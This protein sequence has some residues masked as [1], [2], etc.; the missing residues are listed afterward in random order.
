[1]A[2]PAPAAQ[3]LGGRGASQYI[4]DMR[5]GIDL[6]GTKIE[7]IALGDDGRER[8]RHRVA[9]PQTYE[10][11][12]GALATLVARLEGEAAARGTVGVGTPGFLQPGRGLIRNSN[13][14]CLNDR[15]LDV[16]L[17]HALGRQVRLDND[18]SCFVLSEA[19]DGAA[20]GPSGAPGTKADVVFGATLGTGVGGGL[21]IDGR[22]H[23]GANGAAAEWS[24]TTLPFLRAGE[25]S[26]YVCFCGHAGCIES[27]TSGRGL[28]GAYREVGG[29]P[30]LAAPEVGARAA[31]GEDVAD[32][33]FD[34]YEDRL[35]RA[36][37]GVINLLDPRAIVL[38]G[39]VSNNTRLFANLPRL[40]ERYTV[41]K[42]LR[43]Q[44][45]R[46]LHGDA[47][48]VRGAAFL[49]PARDTQKGLPSRGSTGP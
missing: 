44:I 33:A 9:T 6:G 14:L 36:L 35:A 12:L 25:A 7:G 11:V 5:I 19:V 4:E 48:G 28:A 42:D 37:A 47:S 43:T 13:L 40:C 29:D 23:S 41:A 30:G 22:V 46:A 3:G 39:G 31:A 8:A 32:R 1:V 21:A 10:E 26:P 20:A 45:V 34:L 49:W 38:G 2:S 15:P 27:F 24:H 16:D 17:A 18:A